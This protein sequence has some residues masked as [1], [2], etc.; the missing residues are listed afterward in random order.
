[1]LTV[2]S[3]QNIWKTYITLNVR[4]Q[5]LLSLKIFFI[6]FKDENFIC[7]YTKVFENIDVH[8]KGLILLC[9]LEY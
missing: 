5:P 3:Q 7:L 6:D 1:M 4:K 2:E 9:L 8:K